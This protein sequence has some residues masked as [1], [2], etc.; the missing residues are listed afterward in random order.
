LAA[1]MASPVAFGQALADPLPE[2]IIAGPKRV[3]LVPFAAPPSSSVNRPR[4]RLNLLLPMP[5]GSGRL[6]VNDMRGKLWIIDAD[7]TVDP[8]PMLDLAT[9][10]GV[11]LLS[12]HSEAGFSTFAFHPDFATP[13]E[14]GY[15]KLYTAYESSNTAADVTFATLFGSV[16][17]HSV[18]D[19]WTIDFE[20]P[21]TIDPTTRRQVLR[22]AQP[23]ANHNLGQISFNPNAGPGDSD[24]GKLY[25]AIADGGSGGDPLNLAQNPLSPLGSLL[26]IDPLPDGP[27]SYQVPADNPFIGDAAYLPETWAYGFRNPHRYSWDAASPS[28]TGLMLLSDIGQANIEEVNVIQVGGNYGW[29]LR[30]GTF[31]YVA[32]DVVPL[33]P[34]DAT[35]D[36]IYPI[37][38]YDHDEGDAIVGG[39]VYRGQA[40]PNLVGHYIFGD[41]VRGRL[42]HFDMSTIAPD[43]RTP[44]HE[45]TIYD[46]DQ[47]TTLLELLGND[48][49]ADL[50]FGIDGDGEIYV[51]TKRDGLIR[52]MQFIPD[53]GDFNGDGRVNT[54]D[55]NP[56]VLALTQPEMYAATYPGMDIHVV[57]DFN[58]DGLVNTADINGFVAALTGAGTGVAVNNGIPEPAAATWLAVSAVLLMTRRRASRDTM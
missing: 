7:G 6:V 21:D 55:I 49:R 18:V 34:D 37:A 45:L 52:R 25:V 36:L 48:F 47:P 14:A 32:G 38:Q 53:R 50:R 8:Q 11:N 31:T 44:I 17:H 4:A 3:Q 24:Y 41:I 5:D 42:F 15:G 19:E 13:G 9:L 10:A 28:G 22:F 30:E 2:P 12:A 51:L 43:G 46:A 58:D 20:S 33:P 40:L 29:N 1:G 56:F 16:S 27:S 26:R 39:F 23:F 57:G 35:L 54:A